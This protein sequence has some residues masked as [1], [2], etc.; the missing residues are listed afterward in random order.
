MEYEF[1]SN[2]PIYIQMMKLFKLKI[3]S[4]EWKRGERTPAVRELALE[5]GVNPNTM[6]RS[7]SE[8]EREGLLYSERTSGRY[9]T[10]NEE[11]IAKE[12]D[13]M[14]Q[15]EI[16][17]FMESMKAIGYTREQIVELINAYQSD[18]DK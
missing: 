7:L 9:I 4:G 6:Q 14:A 8:L 11:L 5:Y 12:R 10:S 18:S 15:Q 3:V 16:V 1:N 13:G 2:Q 17:R